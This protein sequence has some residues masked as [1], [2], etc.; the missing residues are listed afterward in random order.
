MADYHRDLVKKY[1][2]DDVE[3]RIRTRAMIILGA[4][5]EAHASPTLQ[6]AIRDLVHE[7]ATPRDLAVLS[8]VVEWLK[9]PTT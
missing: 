6:A 3:R 1:E 9:K 2:N 7:H 4:I 5:T 8:D